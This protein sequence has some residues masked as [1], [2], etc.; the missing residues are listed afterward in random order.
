MTGILAENTGRF[1]NMENF[2]H[3]LLRSALALLSL[4]LLPVAA[5]SAASAA[6]VTTLTWHGHAAFEIT[7]PNGKVLWIDPWLNNPKN[8]DAGPGKDAVAKVT[9]GDYILITHGHFDHMADAVALAKKTGAKLI[10]NYDLGQNLVK[11]YGYPKEQVGFDTQMNIGG[12][13]RIADGEVMVAM[14]P[15]VHS[16]GL[17]N[18]YSNEK[19]HEME[20]AVVS[21][22]TAAGFI[23]RIKNGPTFYDTGDTAYFHDMENI[24]K[25]YRPDVAL[26]NIGGH[27]GMEPMMAAK[28]ASA[29]KVKM[30][31]PMHYG[32]FPVLT[33]DP[34]SF[35]DTVRRYGIRYVGMQPGE[36]LRFS[37][38]QL[39][40]KP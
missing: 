10:S 2:M 19:G 38:K 23:I 9:K 15:A 35:A 13:I 12:E 11:L 21:G 37:G 25:F 28:A 29:V 14:T 6:A 39:V 5:T 33:Q 36:T 1:I 22:G 16:S 20:P 32:T 7:T 4:L 8:P 27:F 34:K 26:V 40:T 17:G 31:I 30:A 3:R 18:P 24:G